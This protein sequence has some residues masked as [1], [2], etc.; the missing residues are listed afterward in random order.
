MKMRW[1]VL[2]LAGL[3]FP[4]PL[5][6]GV[7]AIPLRENLPI[8]A[9]KNEPTVKNHFSLLLTDEMGI[10]VDS[11]HGVFLSDSNVGTD[12][13]AFRF[14][15]DSDYTKGLCVTFLFGE[16]KYGASVLNCNVSFRTES[17]RGDGNLDTRLTD[18]WKITPRYTTGTLPC[19]LQASGR[20]RVS[21]PSGI[22]TGYW[23]PT[24]YLRSGEITMNIDPASW[25]SVQKGLY[26]CDVK[27]FVDV[28]D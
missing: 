12:K 16:L 15:I 19:I 21:L 4:L 25:Q 14:L 9:Y 5:A 7:V 2:L 28:V 11:S 22:Q 6:A 1:T 18:T 10:A 13:V 20:V 17:R 3:L 26:V 23:L 8:S 24:R 27:V